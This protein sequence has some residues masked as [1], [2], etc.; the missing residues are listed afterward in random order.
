MRKTALRTAAALAALAL[1]S[2][3]HDSSSQSCTNSAARNLLA[4]AYADGVINR[5]GQED[6]QF[7]T[8]SGGYPNIFFL[9][10]TSGS[11]VRLPPNGP[12]GF[13][14]TLPASGSVGCGTDTKY[15]GFP[16]GTVLDVVNARTYSSPCG[17]TGAP[18]GQPYL[19]DYTL[20][21]GV[22][23]ADIAKV[24]PYYTSSNTFTT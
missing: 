10:D 5:P 20:G 12:P 2:F 24:C 23:Y 11:M 8:S 3:P 13:T 22:D 15:G 1:L 21:A 18:E 19:G 7:F 9:I 17:G 6:N 16:A 14:G 4:G